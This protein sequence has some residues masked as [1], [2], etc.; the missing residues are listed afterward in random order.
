ME[1]QDRERRTGAEAGLVDGHSSAGV[2]GAG[3]EDPPDGSLDEQ[4]SFTGGDATAMAHFYRGEMNRLTIWR[5]RMDSTTNW[6]II[7]TIGMLSLSFR[8]PNADAIFIFNLAALWFLLAVES[9]R[10]RF[11]D[12]W[13]WRVRILEAHFL[14]PILHKRMRSVRGPW[15]EDLTADLLYPI[16]KI[17]MREA[18][19]RRLLR[20]YIYLYGLLLLAAGAHITGISLATSSWSLLTREHIAASMQENW[21]LLCIIVASYTPL[22]LL[23]LSGWQRRK[24]AVEL[25]DPEGRRSYRV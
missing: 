21:L 12:V 4:Q 1:S 22:I 13:R 20:N 2:P 6:A 7:A 16:F 5:T 10:Y 3:Q 18:M 9:R 15:R 8:N 19:G 14:T 11:Y 17:S 25:H 24:I 23:A